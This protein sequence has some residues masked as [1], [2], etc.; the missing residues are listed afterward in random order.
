MLRTTPLLRVL[1]YA[2]RAVV[3]ALFALF[4][5]SN[6]N[7]H[8]LFNLLILVSETLTVI[9]IL[10]RRSTQAVSQRPLSAC[11][12]HGTVPDG[13]STPDAPSA[14]LRSRSRSWTSQRKIVRPRWDRR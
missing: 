13:E 4:C 10:S 8:H 9:F 5:I 2:E 12:V 3:L 11:G 6:V 1:D 14:D 7:S